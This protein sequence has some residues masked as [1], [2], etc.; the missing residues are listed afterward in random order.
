MA[1]RALAAL[2]WVLVLELLTPPPPLLRGLAVRPLELDPPL[3]RTPGEVVARLP[4]LD[5]AEPLRGRG[6]PPVDP[7]LDPP[8]VY[9]WPLIIDPNE[10]PRGCTTM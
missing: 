5:P 9:P 7:E 2:D 1:V 8:L 3:L 6:Y 4:P 10:E